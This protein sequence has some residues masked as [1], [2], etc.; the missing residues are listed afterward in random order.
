MPKHYVSPFIEADQIL[1]FFS[2]NP[3]LP[4][5]FDGSGL[6]MWM[7][8]KINHKETDRA[9]KQLNKD[10]YVDIDGHWNNWYA[11]N[12]NGETFTKNGG[13]KEDFERFNKEEEFNK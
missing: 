7:K 12:G 5:R 13:Y 9:L 10:G 3:H 2:D 4:K 6:Y 8:D 1:N 11:I